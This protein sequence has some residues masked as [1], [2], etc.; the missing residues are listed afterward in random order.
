M[1]RTCSSVS[2]GILRPKC[3]WTIHTV[4]K[5]GNFSVGKVKGMWHTFICR[6]FLNWIIPL[7]NSKHLSKLIWPVLVFIV[8]LH[9]TSLLGYIGPVTVHHL[10]ITNGIKGSKYVVLLFFS[11][12]WD[13]LVSVNKQTSQTEKVQ[14]VYPQYL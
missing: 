8:S 4:L 14:L 5:N 7:S 13:Y 2:T 6:M 9:L 11:S 10:Y 12:Y 3:G 1:I